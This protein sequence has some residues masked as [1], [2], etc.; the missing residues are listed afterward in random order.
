VLKTDDNFDALA[1]RISGT[2]VI[3]SNRILQNIASISQTLSPTSDN[4]YDW[5]TSTLRWRNIYLA[6][7]LYGK[8]SYTIFGSEGGLLSEMFD[9][10]EYRVD[11]L[12]FRKPYKVEYWDS[13]TSTWV[14]WGTDGINWMLPLTDGRADTAISNPD[15]AH[16]RF[17]IYY[18]IGGWSGFD[19]MVIGSGWQQYQLKVGI[20]SSSYSDFSSDVY[21]VFSEQAIGAGD[22]GIAVIPLLPGGWTVRSYLRITLDTSLTDSSRRNMRLIALLANAYQSS[23]VKYSLLFLNDIDRNVQA[24]GHLT[25]ETDNAFDLGN[26]SYRWRDLWLSRNASIGGNL[27]AGGYGNLGSLQISGT[28]VIS[29]ARVLQ[30]VSGD[31]TLISSL[32]ADLWDGYHF[33]DYLNQ[34]VKTVSSPTFAGL[35][36]SGLTSGSVLFTGSGGL[37]SQDNANLFWDNANKRLGIGTATPGAKLDVRGDIISTLSENKTPFSGYRDL[38]TTT[39]SVPGLYYGSSRNIDN[40]TLLAFEAARNPLSQIWQYDGTTYKDLND[41]RE[42]NSAAASLLNNTSYILYLGYSSIFNEVYFDIL[43]AGSGY[44][45]VWE[46][47][48]GSTWATLSV[49]DGTSNFTADGWVTWTA[50]ANWATTTV[51][52]VS[53]YWIRVRTTTTPTTV[54]TCVFINRGG[55]PGYFARMYAHGYEKLQIDKRGNT[56]L[57]GALYPGTGSPS[58]AIQTSR[59]IIDASD[60]L[61]INTHWAPVSSNTLDLGLSSY[62]WRNLL[63]AGY[64]NVGSL[65]ISGT[66]VISSARVL[67]N[68]SA[69]AGIITSGRFTL[70]RLPTS[71]TANRFLAVRTAN[72]DPIYDALVATDIPD[73]DASKI[74]SG[75]FPLSR[76]PDGASGYVIMGQGAGVDP[77]YTSLAD[78]VATMTALHVSTAANAHPRGG[79]HVT[80]P[81]GAGANYPLSEGTHTHSG[82]PVKELKLPM[83]KKLKIMD[84]ERAKK[85]A[86]SIDSYDK[87][88]SIEKKIEVFE[89]LFGLD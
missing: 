19:M 24:R 64:A 28:E 10:G 37:I 29:S 2:E 18:N 11:V 83:P 5:G 77:V 86:D 3:S 66:E 32:N 30:N 53:A 73:L 45:L 74:T 36:L 15:D 8:T 41:R 88:W 51:N 21:T 80:A 33:A 7:G 17:R 52:G 89:L 55:F 87:N 26:T 57:G 58:S 16:A 50:P 47:W 67:Y 13:S 42:W 31:G 54:A 1:L 22:Y 20:E 38:P 35:T 12:K 40:A 85:I 71:A 39:F 27:T 82:E 49:T 72:A 61:R 79:Y 65:Q 9:L 44:T 59:Y 46:Y 75:R 63:L 60:S 69:D 76:L 4:T 68:V 34:A 25:T 84:E 70:A 56:Y 43:A 23:N 14:D 62:M 81:W 48:N 6:R 78:Q